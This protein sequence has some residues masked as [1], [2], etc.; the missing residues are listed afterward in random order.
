MVSDFLDKK[1]EYNVTGIEFSYRVKYIEENQEEKRAY[2]VW[3][4]EVKNK[5]TSDKAKIY[6]NAVSGEVEIV[7]LP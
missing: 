1:E 4:F 6:I 5:N 2:P 3:K 7:K